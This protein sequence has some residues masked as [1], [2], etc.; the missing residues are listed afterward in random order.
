MSV[1]IGA[2]K[3]NLANSTGSVPVAQ[4]GTGYTANLTTSAQTSAV[5]TPGSSGIWHQLTSNSVTLGAGRYRL[6]GS[7]VFGSSGGS[8][9]YSRVG[10]GIFTSNGADSGSV[11]TLIATGGNITLLTIGINY[12]FVTASADLA[13]IN[14]PEFSVSLSGSTTFY[15]V[16][17]SEQSTSANARITGLLNA[18]QTL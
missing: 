14:T 11:P 2:P 3:P 4:G 18:T 9:V 13:Q 6:Y 15:V 1:A 16:T 10:V 17:Y 8:P 7:A 5:K 12:T